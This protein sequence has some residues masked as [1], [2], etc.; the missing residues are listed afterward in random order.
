MLAIIVVVGVL[1]FSAGD[2]AVEVVLEMLAIVFVEVLAV[3]VGDLA[4]EVVV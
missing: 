1:A 4:V 2:L 3:V